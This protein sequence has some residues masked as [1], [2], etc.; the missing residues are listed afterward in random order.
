MSQPTERSR[1]IIPVTNPCEYSFSSSIS[2]ERKRRVKQFQCCLCALFLSILLVTIIITVIYSINANRIVNSTIPENDGNITVETSVISFISTTFPITD[3]QKSN[4]ILED[5]EL[6]NEAIEEGK[7]NLLEKD[8]IEE[9]IPSL[10]I[11]SPSYRHQRVT[12]TSKRG[13]ELSRVGFVEEFATKH[14]YR[15]VDNTTIDIM[16]QNQGIPSGGCCQNKT[17]QCNIFHKYRSFNGTCNN[18]KKPLDYGTAYRPFRRMLPPNYADAISKPRISETGEPLPS[19]RTVS[20]V[21]HRP[22]YRDDPKF[23]VMLAVWGQFLDHDITATALSQKVDGSTISCCGQNSTTSPECFPVYLDEN[24][25]FREYNVSCMEFVRS[26][27]AP[28][29]CLGPREQMNQVTSYIDGSVV[30]SVDEDFAKK[31]R[32]LKNG[33]LKVLVTSDER[34]LLP[35]SDDLNDGCNREEYE[36]NGKYCF[37]TGDARA[38]E[39]LHLTT[40]HLLWVRQHNSIASNLSKLNSHWDDERIFQETRRIIA[41]QIQHITYNEFLPILLGKSLMKKFNLYPKKKEYFKMYND[42]LDPSIANNFATAAF[43]FAHSIIPGLMKLLANDTSS[44]DFIQMHKML[45]N[46][47]DLYEPGGLDKTLRGAMNTNIQA[48]DSYFTNELKS[49]MFE[50]TVEQTKQPKLCGLDLVSLNVQRGRD[51]GLPGYTKWRQH[52]GLKKPSNFKDLQDEMDPDSLHNMEMIYNNIDDVDLYTGALSE[53][54]IKGSILGPTIMCLILDQFYRLK[55]GDRFWYENPHPPQGFAMDQLNELRKTTL[56]NIICDNADN[57]ETIQR[58][59]M[60]K[61]GKNNMYVSCKD[62]ERTNLELWK[63]NL[64][65]LDFVTDETKI[66][67]KKSIV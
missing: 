49:H 38:N 56:A 23:T 43:R 27:P 31:L 48:S 37:L 34:T 53:K 24:D 59:V 26:A 51:H 62:I 30:Y 3:K 21:I 16:C 7:R 55:H 15:N 60:Q 2:R 29:C 65:R 41:A 17:I 22:Y 6:W 25:P 47:F 28:T 61:A 5:I 9:A 58:K 4:K 36:M 44:P 42:S 50:R 45:F 18:L 66:I 1:L 46:P 63:E 19:A 8:K 10:N 54:P 57:L 12:A 13:R 40:M 32:T 35:V 67:V 64:T 39:N 14:I 52:C 11:Q 33:M 20:L